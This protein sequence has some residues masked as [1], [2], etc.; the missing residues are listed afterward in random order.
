MSTQPE[1]KSQIRASD[2]DRQHV[3]DRLQ[4]AATDGRLT[5]TEADER[6]ATAYASTFQDELTWLTD[7]LP[8][9]QE[10]IGRA[11]IGRGRVHPAIAAHAAIAVLLSIALIARW[12][13][14]G[15]EFFWPLFPMFWLTV[16]VL[17]H[18]RVRTGRG[19]RLSTGRAFSA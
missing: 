19:R 17:V 6:I 4:K 5:V 13:G 1:P 10:P 11:S 18:A 12:A 15:A 2:A 8:G 14:S 3:V 9:G 16:S 7:D